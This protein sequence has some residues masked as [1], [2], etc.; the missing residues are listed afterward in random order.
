MRKSAW[1]RWS[2]RLLI[3]LV[4]TTVAL[5]VGDLVVGGLRDTQRRHLLRL[6]ANANVRHQSTEFDYQ[7]VT[8]SL[9]LR[10]PE[11]PLAKPAG[12]RRAVVLGDSLVAGYGVANEEV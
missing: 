4:A 2:A 10:G 5:K 8:N 3:L 6:P 1:L 12:A 11:R 9:G 7:F